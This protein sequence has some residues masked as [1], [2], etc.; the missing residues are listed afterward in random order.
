MDTKAEAN[1]SFYN[2]YYSK[3]VLYI[4]RSYNKQI[5]EFI[6]QNFLEFFELFRKQGI[7][8]IYMPYLINNQE[9][10]NIL[11]YNHPYLEINNQKEFIANLYNEIFLKY[12]IEDL[13]YGLLAISNSNK[14]EFFNFN[15]NDLLTN[16]ILSFLDALKVNQEYYDSEFH[17]MFSISPCESDFIS[18]IE[19][20]EYDDEIIEDE[21]NKIIE[22]LIE[23]GALGILSR[24]I[25]KINS[26][27]FKISRLLIT[28]DYKIFLKDYNM[29]LITMSP[30]EKS[31][32]ILYLNHPEGIPFKCLID[33]HDELL[34]IYRNLT[35][36]SDLEKAIE[37]IRELTN[38]LSNSINEKVSRIR[39]AFL[40]CLTQEIAK[41]YYIVG[42]KG[43]PKKITLDRNLI[44]YQ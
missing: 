29:K 26:N 37:S 16:Q 39:A 31:I 14:Y 20:L 7:N 8:F 19:D 23:K 21:I 40:T 18:E 4:E 38:P 35:N 5:N 36:R 25:D 44:E 28:E 1:I 41:N 24:I 10:L 17:V 15:F 33:F 2:P 3:S 34:S 27:S 9:Y 6:Q 11:K 43:C 32:F 30:L 12:N 13:N 42:K 22:K